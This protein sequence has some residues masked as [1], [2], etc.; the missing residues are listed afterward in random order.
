[1]IFIAD[2]TRQIHQ[3]QLHRLNRE[4]QPGNGVGRV[5][6]DIKLFED[7]Q[8]NQRSDPLAVGRQLLDRSAGKRLRQ[9]ADPVGAMSVEILQRQRGVMLAGE[10]DHLL[11]QLAAIKTLSVAFGDRLQRVGLCRIAKQFASARRP[12]VGRKTCA[13]AGLML[14]LV[15]TALP[16]FGDQRRDRKTVAR[17]VD[18]RLCQRGQRQGAEALRQRR[19]GRYRARHG[20]RFPADLRHAAAANE[21]PGMPGGRRAARRVQTMQPTAVPDDGEGVA[22]DAVAGRLQHRQRHGGGDRRVH[23]VAA[24]QQH[25]Q[26]RLR[27]QR[28]RSGHRVAAHH[29]HAMRRVAGVKIELRMHFPFLS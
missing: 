19:P 28:L 8:R 17:V 25:T 13:K 27:R 23:R 4:V 10:G 20:D 12:A 29:R 11:R 9:H 1:M 7:A 2:V 24:L 14:E 16:E 6:A 5:A 18:G 22:A 21:A 26:T 3:R 15:E